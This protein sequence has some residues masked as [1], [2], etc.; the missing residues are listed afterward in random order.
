MRKATALDVIDFMAMTIFGCLS[1]GYILWMAD[2]AELHISM[3]MPGFPGLYRRD[4]HVSRTDAGGSEVAYPPTYAQRRALCGC[5][6]SRVCAVEG[7]CGIRCL[8]AAGLSACRLVLLSAVCGV[9][10]GLFLG[11]ISQEGPAV[12][13]DPDLHGLAIFGFLD[14][15][16]DDLDDFGLCPVSVFSP[17]GLGGLSSRRAC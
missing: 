12:S 2:F 17:W 13:L 16:A 7:G 3:K 14:I 15:L 11:A 9:R 5:G 1:L 4:R 10:D 6:L 8:R